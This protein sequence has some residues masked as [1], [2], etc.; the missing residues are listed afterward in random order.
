MAKPGPKPKY[1]VRVDR[2]ILLSSEA[3]TFLETIRSKLDPNLSN[4]GK[5][6]G[7]SDALE[8]FMRTHFELPI[9]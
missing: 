8:H 1:G 6:V 9:E 5:P 7:I 4:N 3:M 2:R